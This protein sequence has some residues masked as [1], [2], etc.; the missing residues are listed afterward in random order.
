[1]HVISGV[2]DPAVSFPLDTAIDDAGERRQA[3]RAVAVSA[4]GLAVT[5]IV[6]LA[7][8]LVSGSVALLGDALHNLSDVSTSV[9]VFVGFRA[10][11]KVPTD[12]YPYGYER[13][14]DLAGI[15]VALVIWGSAAV[16][17]F[18]SVT[19]L[20]RHGSTGHVGWGIAAAA[21]G[22]A[23]NQLVARY[24]LA[25]GRRIR[26]ATMV[27]DAK[28]S[29][30]DALSSAGAMLG[31][32]GVA[33]GWGWADAVAGIVVTGFICHVGWEV[34]ADI[35]HR[36]LDGV[37]PEVVTTAETVAATIPGVQHAHARARWTGRTL[38]VEVE[39][40]LD[41]DTSLADADRIG[42]AVAAALTPK[43]PDMQSFTWAARA[44]S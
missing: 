23:G 41:P 24:K 9:L 15:G 18:E 36:L 30:L 25:V 33:L 22:I 19:K 40:F 44:A 35:A 42:R 5:G 38:R 16:A 3:N 26:S 2:R 4:V 8:A 10:S 11:R 34:S 28:H 20:L 6:E 37:D 21:V 13:A 17:G 12:R 31:L 1:M 14:E 27:A 39:G 29:W 43:V 7:I 32:I